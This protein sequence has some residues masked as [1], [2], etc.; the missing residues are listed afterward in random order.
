MKLIFLIAM[1]INI[2]AVVCNAPH[3]ASSFIFCMNAF[4]A[5]WMACLLVTKD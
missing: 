1:L 5:G 3:N 4:W 2:L